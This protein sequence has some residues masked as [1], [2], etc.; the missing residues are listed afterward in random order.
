MKDLSVII[1]SFNTKDMTVKCVSSLAECLSKSSLSWEIIVV[2]NGS[3]DGTIQ[4]IRN[5]KFEIRIIQN[6]KNVGFGKANNQGLKEAS[7]AYVLFLNSDVIVEKELDFTDLLHYFKS[8]KKVGVITVRV[9]LPNGSIDPASHR[10]FP[11]LWRSSCYFLGLE[12]IFAHIPFLN[13]VFGGYHLIHLDMGTTHEIDS[14]TGA[15]Y[16][17][18]R[19]VLNRVKG[20]DEDFFMYGEDLDLSFRIKQEG[21]KAL[22]IP[23]YSAVH[24]K[25]QSGIQN[26]DNDIIRK[27]I[28]KYFYEAM[29]IFYKKHYAHMYPSFLNR[30]VYFLIDIKI[31]HI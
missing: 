15:F 19:D 18:P 26:K 29:T 17:A 5:S 11:T 16:L 20:F 14:P 25:G 22:Y 30:F 10:G 8:Q 21:Y 4:E 27:K 24:H 3:S 2:D 13:R 1:P 28:R 6:S 12:K 7:G 23:Q 31:K 9:N